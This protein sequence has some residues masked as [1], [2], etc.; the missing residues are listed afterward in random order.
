MLGIKCMVYYQNIHL[1]IGYSGICMSGVCTNRM[2]ENYGLTHRS[3]SSLSSSV[4][5]GFALQVFPD[6][7]VRFLA[8]QIQI[9]LSLNQVELVA[10]L[11]LLHSI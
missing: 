7:T 3:M 2:L 8:N 1:G 6:I 11:T 4:V 5:R 10:T 9:N